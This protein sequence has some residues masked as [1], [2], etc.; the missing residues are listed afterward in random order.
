MTKLK[1]KTHSGVKRRFRVS[2]RGKIVRRKS[3]INNARR[4]KRRAV[5]AEFHTMQGVHR[6]FRQRVRRLLPYGGT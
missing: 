3:H 6:S 1:L 5:K 4:K 2:G